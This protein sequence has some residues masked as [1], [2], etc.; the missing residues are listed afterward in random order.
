VKTGRGQLVDISMTDVV[1]SLLSL[2]LGG[3]FQHG[4]R[5][6]D[7]IS[8]GTTHSNNFYKTKDGKYI[9]IACAAEPWF[10]ANLCKALGCEEFIPYQTDL[11]K[12]PEIKAF[13]EQKF[14]SKTRDEWFNILSQLDIPVGK[15]Y[16]LDELASDPQ[17]AHRQMIV[18]IDHPVE[19]KIKQAGISIKLSETPGRIRRL[20]Q[21]LGENTEEVLREVGYSG[22]EIEK[23]RKEGVV[24]TGS[25][26]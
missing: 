9:S 1:V 7:R 19:G 6:E 12:A 22:E 2:Y 21:A 14:F 24:G 8:A 4:A 18:E 13:F 10:Y 5:Q 16:S 17:L 23:L 15:A 3:H 25:S 11:E 26:S 20:G